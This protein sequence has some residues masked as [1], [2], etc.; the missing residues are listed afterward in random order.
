MFRTV[1]IAQQNQSS[2]MILQMIYR[3]KVVIIRTGDPTKI[4]EGK[5]TLKIIRCQEQSV[6]DIPGM[7]A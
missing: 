6:V 1:C 2:M 7:F 5:N 3:G 4:N